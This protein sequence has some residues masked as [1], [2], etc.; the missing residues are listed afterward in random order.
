MTHTPINMT[1]RSF[2]TASGA[3]LAGLLLSTRPAVAAMHRYGL[4]AS[5]STVGFQFTLAG[6]TQTG[7]MPISQADIRIDTSNLVRSSVDVS[8]AV[9]KART[10]L[11]L[12]TDAL[13]G[14]DVLDAAR[15]PS[16]RFVSTKVTL[17]PG[18]RISDGATLT[19]N[20]TVRNV[21]KPVTFAANIYRPAGSGAD[22][23]N[24]LSVRLTGAISRTAFGATGYS[25]LVADRITLD[26]RAAIQKS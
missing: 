9:N 6:A 1:R 26:I 3:S 14:P 19:G 13:K 18:G 15:F 23:L 10:G 22:D 7:T 8:V 20:L 17:G 24:S 25:D 21:T 2:L 16:I 4:T 12:A 5:S 11:A